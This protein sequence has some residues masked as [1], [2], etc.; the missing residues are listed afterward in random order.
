MQHGSANCKHYQV[1]SLIPKEWRGNYSMKTGHIIWVSSLSN[2]EQ[3]LLRLV[4]NLQ[5]ESRR[6][7]TSAEKLGGTFS[8]IAALFHIFESSLL[9]GGFVTC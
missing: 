7:V 1:V 6:L 3:R 4:E 9:C 2:R 8:G 5:R